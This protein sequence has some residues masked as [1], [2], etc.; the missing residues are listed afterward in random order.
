MGSTHPTSKD[1]KS[2]ATRIMFY[3]QRSHKYEQLV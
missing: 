3:E 1:K 2:S